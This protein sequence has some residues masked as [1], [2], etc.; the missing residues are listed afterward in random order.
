MA[1]QQDRTVKAITPMK[2]TEIPISSPTSDGRH[3]PSDLEKATSIE[4][5]VHVQTSPVVS[6]W[7]GPDDVDNPMNWGALK[8]AYHTAATAFLGF[9]VTAGSSLITPATPEIQRYFDVSQTASILSLSLFVL[10]LGLGPALAAPI[11]E[12]FGRSVVYK[13]SGPL[14]LLFILGSGFSKSFGGLLVCR[15]LAGMSGG[16]VLAVGAGTNADLYPP[17]FRA[18]A[19]TMFVMMPFLGPALGP[20]IGGFVAQYKGWQWTQWTTIFIG[21]LA[22]LSTLP[23]QE[24]YKKVILKQRA[25]RSGLQ[26]PPGST[27]SGLAFAKILVTVTL[28]RPVH[29]L[30]TEPITFMLSLYTAFTFS[31]LFSFFA[32]YPY[33]FKGIYGFETWQYGLT[34]LAIG[35]G[36]LLAV[37]TAIVIDRTYYVS[38]HKKALAAGRTMVAP[39]Y[40]LL[41][42]QMG[43][44]GVSIG[45]FWFSWTA[46]LS[47]HWIV[48]VLAGIPFAWGNL[49]IFVSAALYLMDTYGPLIGASAMAAN[50][51]ARYSLGAAFPLFTF[52][53]LE[54]LGVAWSIS[55]LGFLSLAMLPIPWI[56]FKYGPSIRA[57]SRY[58]TFK[59]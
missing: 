30:C 19:T 2:S 18:V 3:S 43:C 25:K 26:P 56:F 48:P 50:G 41:S 21:L 5:P 32:A 13:L 11:S 34:F 31:V 54:R 40:R 57:R 42:A 6:D 53:M 51:L 24:T 39:E 59:E 27:P 8:K 12:Q 55:L 38:H 15:L 1:I 58:D 52:Q 28:V 35:L 37:M 36:V 33:V 23:M 44:F 4:A 16:P 29:M 49:C 10:G 20:V 45:L 17:V 47:V 46:R 22:V 14:Y 7:N 9:A